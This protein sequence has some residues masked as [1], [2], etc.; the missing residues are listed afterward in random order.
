[1]KFSIVTITLTA[2]IIMGCGTIKDTSQ[3]DGVLDAKEMMAQGYTKGEIVYSN[4]EGDCEF[5]IKTYNEPIEFLDPV[6]LDQ[7]YKVDGKQVWFKY[8][9]L[10]QK[11]RCDK[12]RPISINEI[13]IIKE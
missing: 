13:L 7:E 11:N 5:T 4:V 10:R 6:N 8:A 9:S 3:G 12:A 2:L 1:M